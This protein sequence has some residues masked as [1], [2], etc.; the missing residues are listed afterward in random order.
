[1]SISIDIVCLASEKTSIDKYGV[2]LLRSLQEFR[3]HLPRF[4]LPPK[5]DTSEQD[6]ICCIR[7]STVYML[8]TRHRTN[9]EEKSSN[10]SDL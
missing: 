1:M 9:F 3:F 5:C 2:D 7:T 4:P 10:R 6:S 8:A